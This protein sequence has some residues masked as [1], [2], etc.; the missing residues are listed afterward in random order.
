VVSH[1]EMFEV[2]CAS[3]T[4]IAQLIF[5][6][7]TDRTTWIRFPARAKFLL[8][9]AI[10]KPPFSGVYPATYPMDTV[11][12]FPEVKLTKRGADRQSLCNAKFMSA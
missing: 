11:S 5:W 2:A 12:Y 6:V 8:F 9:A 10:C 1:R 4:W 3:R 7:T